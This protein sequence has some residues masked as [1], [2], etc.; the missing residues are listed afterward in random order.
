MVPVHHVGECGR[1]SRAVWETRCTW[2]N[3]PGRTARAFFHAAGRMHRPSGGGL[4]AHCRR[5]G[6]IGRR[7]GFVHDVLLEVRRFQFR[8]R[9]KT[10]TVRLGPLIY[11]IPNE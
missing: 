11:V 4:E 3:D 5:V 8:K 6:T 9:G 2:R 1:P 7:A 10:R